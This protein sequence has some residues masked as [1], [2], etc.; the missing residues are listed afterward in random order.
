M[1]TAKTAKTA[2]LTCRIE[3]ALKAV[4]RMAAG[5]EH[6][7]CA[8]MIAVMIR[9]YCGRVGVELQ[10]LPTPAVKAARKATPRKR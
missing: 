5:H 8:N 3:P 9:D 6:Q 4:M 1:D 10:E 7:A 2:T